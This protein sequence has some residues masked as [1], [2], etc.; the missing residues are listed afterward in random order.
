M[1]LPITFR[2]NSVIQYTVF[3]DWLLSFGIMF[4]RFI[5]IEACATTPFILWLSS[6]PMHGSPHL[7]ICSSVDGNLGCYHLL[8]VM[9]NCAIN[10]H[11]HFFC[12]GFQFTWVYTYEWICWFLNTMFEE[13]PI[14]QSG[15]TIIHFHQQFMIQFFTFSP[16]FPYLS[17]F[18]NF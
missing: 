16:I 11:V 12:T 5:C 3:C 1:D 17:F 13:P 18:F 15:C 7:F 2:K 6:I 9:N 4:S 14:F 8:T 10:I